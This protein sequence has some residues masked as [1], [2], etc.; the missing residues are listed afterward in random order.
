MRWHNEWMDKSRAVKKFFA[1]LFLVGQS[2]MKFLTLYFMLNSGLLF[3]TIMWK[4]NFLYVGKKC[5]LY[6][7]A[8]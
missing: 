6:E 3:P 7:F 2:S 1:S 5:R 4:V 8:F